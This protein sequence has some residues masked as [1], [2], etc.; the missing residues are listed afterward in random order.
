MCLHAHAHIHTHIERDLHKY[1]K[2]A[3][4]ISLLLHKGQNKRTL[5]YTYMYSFTHIH[6]TDTLHVHEVRQGKL[7]ERTKFC[8]GLRS[9]TIEEHKMGKINPIQ[10]T[11]CLDREYTDTCSNKE[12]I[13]LQVFSQKL[14]NYYWIMFINPIYGMNSVRK[15]D[16]SL[17]LGW[18]RGLGNGDYVFIHVHHD[19]SLDLHYVTPCTTHVSVHVHM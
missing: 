2:E 4:K 5:M 14:L 6:S 3:I 10:H 16:V 19:M 9:N 13:S 15:E 7:Q 11:L 18:L 8:N 17:L 1:N 12:R